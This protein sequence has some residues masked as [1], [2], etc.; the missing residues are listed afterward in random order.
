M[1]I[2][3]SGGLIAQFRVK[4][5]LRDR[6]KAAQSQ[7]SELLELMEKVRGGKFTNFNLDDEGVFVD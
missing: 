1:K 3:K 5:I 2:T 7:D 6:K 4:S